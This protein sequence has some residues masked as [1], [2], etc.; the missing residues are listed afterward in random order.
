M[1][2]FDVGIILC[3]ICYVNF[4]TSI[5]QDFLPPLIGSFVLCYPECRDQQQA[6]ELSY[7]VMVESGFESN[8]VDGI[9][10]EDPAFHQIEVRAE[11]NAVIKVIAAKNPQYARAIIMKDYHD[12]K[13]DEIARRLK[14]T[15]RNVR[16]YISEA[17]KIGK[18]F[19]GDNQ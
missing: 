10:Y 17:K 15:E 4:L 1:T 12:M 11:L 16:F 18:K 6:N 13:V 7:D 9:V 8:G 14:T 19:K 3:F 5:S 2:V